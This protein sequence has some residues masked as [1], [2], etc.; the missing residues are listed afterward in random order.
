VSSGLT[1]N[2]CSREERAD[3]LAMIPPLAARVQVQTQDGK[4]AY[5]KVEEITDTDEIC[6]TAEGKPVVMLR[7]PGRRAK[8]YLQPVSHQVAD[9][10]QAKGFHI[11][12]NDLVRL[13]SENPES[14]AVFNTLMEEFSR[15]IAKL[16]F[17]VQELDRKGKPSSDLTTKRIRAI[18]QMAD[19]WLKR[20]SAVEGGSVD[21]ES[22]AFKALFGFV[23]ETFRGA[24]A[25]AGMRPEHIETVFAKLSKRL[26]DGWAEDA[27]AKMKG[28]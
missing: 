9:E 12:T 2:V 6:V 10:V 18:K 7:P 11:T 27:K 13:T 22:G 23:M 16:G 15:E 21:L 19:T 28:A 24:L 3:V 1:V 17:A 5:R 26:A 8:G 14:D 4:V 20:R 25:D